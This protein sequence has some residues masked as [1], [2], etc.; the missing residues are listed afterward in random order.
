MS[1][2]GNESYQYRDV[3]VDSS[4][5]QVCLYFYIHAQS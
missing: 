4:D 3:R 2:N 1:A 5:L